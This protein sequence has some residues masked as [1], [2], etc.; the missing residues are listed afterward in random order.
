[1]QGWVKLHRKIL[2][3]AIFQNEKL[4]KIFIYFLAKSSHKT[5]E[6]RVGRQKIELK[7]GQLIFGRKKA[8]SE[9]DMKESTVR[10]YLKML[11]EDGVISIKSTNKYSVITVDNWGLY[12]S[13]SEEYDNKS[14]RNDLQKDSLS[15][16][17]HQQIDTY[18]NER[19]FKEV[20]NVKELINTTTSEKSTSEAIHFFEENFGVIRPYLMKEIVTWSDELGD[21]LVIEAMKRSL[22]RG[23]L[24]WGYVKSILQSWVNKGIRTLDQAK[25][26]E[27][28]H[29]LQRNKYNRSPVSKQHSKS[30]TPEWIRKEYNPAEHTEQKQPRLEDVAT[31]IKLRIKYKKEP[32]EIIK[33]NCFGY[34]LSKEDIIAIRDGK[35]TAEEV[36]R[37]KTKL[38][39]VGDP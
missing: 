16:S 38:R 7:P 18:K 21:Q 25:S 39:V 36:L 1:M 24:N 29:Q 22:Y 27:S 13:T 9:L 15:P 3:S 23:K 20:K 17:Q 4:L 8:A 30:V 12:Q 11:E 6:V 2:H 32:D 33:A 37:S 31:I 26:E 5:N 34:D 10:D 19:E 14:P 35:S 28:Q